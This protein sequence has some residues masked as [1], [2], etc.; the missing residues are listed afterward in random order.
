MP[1]GTARYHS[2]RLDGSFVTSS[3]LNRLDRLTP[4]LEPKGV[5]VQRLG[6]PPIFFCSNKRMVLKGLLD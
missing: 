3:I 4:A 2:T 1:H 6:V 5:A